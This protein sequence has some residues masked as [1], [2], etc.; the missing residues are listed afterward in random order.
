MNEDWYEQLQAVVTKV[1]QHGM[2]LVMGDMNAKFES[3]NIDRDRVMDNK[4]CG[5]I[6]N[7][8]KRLIN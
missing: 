5:N 8:I 2:L 1:P 3:G 7:N 4:D 6:N